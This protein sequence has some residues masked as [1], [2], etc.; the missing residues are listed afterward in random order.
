M[1]AASLLLVAAQAA[2]PDRPNPMDLGPAVGQALQGFEASDQHGVVRTLDSLKGPNGLMLL[3]FR[4][5]DW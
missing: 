5:A 4:S 3:I 2:L 1:L